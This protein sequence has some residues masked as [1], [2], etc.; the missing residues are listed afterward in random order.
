MSQSIR[1]HLFISGRVQGVGYRF[2][3]VDTASQLGLSGW[4]RNLPDGRV[5]AV[6]EG[7]QEVV[8]EMIRWCHQGPP[9]AM[10]KDVVVEYEKPEGLNRFEVRRFE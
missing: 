4:V 6:F 9:A 5:E 2:A 8:E 3:T 10:V 1:A 7:V